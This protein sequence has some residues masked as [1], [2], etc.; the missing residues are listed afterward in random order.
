MPM[1][2]FENREK[3]R[4]LRL[5][6]RLGAIVRVTC[7]KPLEVEAYSPKGFHFRFRYYHFVM[8]R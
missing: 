1:K 2:L 4:A 6:E 3:R 7:T 5:A 8:V